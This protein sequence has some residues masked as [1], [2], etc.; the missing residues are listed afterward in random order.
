V[1]VRSLITKFGKTV[2]ILT[3]SSGSLDSSGGRVESWGTST[4]ETGF[5]QVRSVTDE[6]A[7]GAERSTRRA[8]IYFNGTPTITVA[9]RISYDST[10][11]EVSTVRVPQE[12][13]T[14]DA[15]CFTIVEAV[16]VFG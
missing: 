6:I 10:T 16:E 11:W 7:G 1:T 12:R 14:S 3:K 2:A 8:T 15:L 5:V 4:N 13:T 9:D